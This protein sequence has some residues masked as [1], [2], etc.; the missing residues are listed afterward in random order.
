MS[1]AEF[2]LWLAVADD[3]PWDEHHDLGYAQICTQ[4]ARFSGKMLSKGFSV[5]PHDFMPLPQ[6]LESKE[7]PDPLKHFSQFKK[8]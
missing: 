8:G 1:S 2:S 5:N 7:E 3:D 6:P 4:V